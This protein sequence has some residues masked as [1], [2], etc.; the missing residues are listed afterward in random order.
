MLN[1][2]N[3]LD[4]PIFEFDEKDNLPP[5]IVCGILCCCPRWLQFAVRW[6]WWWRC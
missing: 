5:R 1:P 4:I 3:K 6:Q 2:S